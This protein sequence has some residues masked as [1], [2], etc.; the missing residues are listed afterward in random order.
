MA[1]CVLSPSAKMFVLGDNTWWKPLKG[2][3][4]DAAM[5]FLGLG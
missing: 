4:K 1:H 5:F 2:K 3:D